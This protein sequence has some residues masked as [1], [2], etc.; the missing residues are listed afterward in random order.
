MIVNNIKIVKVKRLLFIII[1]LSS[2]NLLV[3][4]SSVDKLKLHNL[5]RQVDFYLTSGN[6]EK[7]ADLRDQAL[8]LFKKIGAENDESTFSGL[9]MI[10]HTYSERKMYND[11]IK[12]E[13]V[14]VEVFPLA[15]PNNKKD[16]ALY[17]ND[18]AF[19][20]LQA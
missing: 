12:T 1:L 5:L 16:Y 7:A 11:A 10:S 4:A 8:V 15:I 19:Y 9:H 14:L 20:S 2:Y 13:S 3:C 18:L 6:F 17:L